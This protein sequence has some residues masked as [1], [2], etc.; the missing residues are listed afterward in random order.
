MG[1]NAFAELRGA[2]SGPRLAEW[3]LAFACTVL[4]GSN[5][6]NRLG[7]EGVQTADR[8]YFLSP[9]VQVL[10]VAGCLVDVAVILGCVAWLVWPKRARIWEMVLLVV[11]ALGAP[12]AWLE[13]VHAL[14]TQPNGVYVLG[15][16][17]YRPI[18]NVGIVGSTVFLLYVVAAQRFGRTLRADVMV[19]A[20]IGIAV[21]LLQ[22]WAFSALK[23]KVHG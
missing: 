23:A 4:L 15:E 13:L 1:T 12:I 18:N 8:Y 16:L 7:T 21:A 17:P 5:L 6:Q 2:Y 3:I 9:Q 14:S 20:G 10:Q 19:K 22:L 11:V